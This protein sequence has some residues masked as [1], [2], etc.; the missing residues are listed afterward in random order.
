M[1]PNSLSAPSQVDLADLADFEFSNRAF[2]EAR[3][4]AR[5]AS[6][7]ADGGIQAAI[8]V[9]AQEAAEDR[10]YQFLVRDGFGILVGRVNFIRVR[11]AHFH[12]AEIGYRVAEAHNGKGYASQAVQL[13]LLVAFGELGLQRIEATASQRNP[14]SAA[15]LIKNGF[16]QFGLSTRSFHLAGEWHDLLHFEC[17]A[18]AQPVIAADGFAAR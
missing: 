13:A 17:H 11:R 18:V 2:F 9:A 14:S 7:Y 4:N 5:P 16:K 6:Y 12:S 8:S 3:I 10:A 15:V 1:P